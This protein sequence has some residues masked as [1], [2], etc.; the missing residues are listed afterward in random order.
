MF[1]GIVMAVRTLVAFP[2][3]RVGVG[4]AETHGRSGHARTWSS[5]QANVE[6]QYNPD[7]PSPPP[8]TRMNQRPQPS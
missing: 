6:A 2:I 4:S 3:L 7:A 1:D 5:V 8:S